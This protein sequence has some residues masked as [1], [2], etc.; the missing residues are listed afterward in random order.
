ML[1]KRNLVV[2][3][4]AEGSVIASAALRTQVPSMGVDLSKPLHL[5]WLVAT[6]AIAAMGLGLFVVLSTMR[7]TPDEQNQTLGI[8]L[9]IVGLGGL[10]SIAGP[11]LLEQLVG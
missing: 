11:G 3:A 1:N 4:I 2:L 6:C 10:L 7:K 8:A 5:A 9:A